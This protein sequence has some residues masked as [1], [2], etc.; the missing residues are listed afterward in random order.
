MRSYCHSINADLKNKFFFFQININYKD[1]IDLINFCVVFQEL[2]NQS[3]I[4]YL[5][6]P[7]RICNYRILQGFIIK[8]VCL[9]SL[10]TMQYILT[11]KSI[12]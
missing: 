8:T 5:C 11:I 3:I 10:R 6:D 7:S 4:S 9:S 2:Y 12:L 1:Q